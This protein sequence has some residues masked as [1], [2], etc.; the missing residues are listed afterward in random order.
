[1]QSF[2]NNS[3]KNNDKSSYKTK[4]KNKI[5]RRFNLFW[6]IEK[7]EL[8]KFFSITAL[9]FSIL[10]IQ[11]LIRATKDSYVI[12]M[13][14]AEALPFLKSGGVLPAA[15]IFTAIYVK[16]VNTMKPE[17]LFYIIISSF[18]FLFAVYGFIL[19]PN[20]QYLQMSEENALHLA[21]FY[22]K[23][24]WIILIFSKWIF[25][26]FY[27]LAELWPNAAFA[28]LFWQFV[29][30]ITA[31]EE[32]KRFYPLFALLGQTGLIF[33]GV[34]LM[35]NENIGIFLFNNLGL[36]SDASNASRGFIF[37]VICSS[38]IVA[39]FTFRYINIHV[40]GKKSTDV[41]EFKVKASQISIAES[42]KMALRSRYIRLIIIMLICYGFAINICESPWKGQAKLI[43]TSTENYNSFVGGYLLLTGI[44]TLTFVILG[45]GLV[46]TL[47]WFY[48][49]IITPILLFIT[50]SLFFFFSNHS[51]QTVLYFAG[52]FM[53]DPVMIAVV[54]GAIMNV[55]TKSSKYTLFDSTK[56]MTYV[57]LDDEL[58]TRG[59][60]AADVIGIKLGKSISGLFLSLT[61]IIFHDQNF[62]T[63]SKYFLFI[64]VAVCLIWFWSV[65][66]LAKEYKKITEKKH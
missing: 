11:N 49:A 45:S 41:I 17:T 16:L 66:E 55:V 3:P 39:L 56:E 18:I 48:A 62:Q 20:H 29:N 15:F 51:S 50:G 28:L 47:G 5:K 37:G 22:P 46:R 23:L 40:L 2:S 30:S 57:P 34:I 24:K 52:F 4:I 13:I 32:S 43:Y 59:K 27:I 35:Y 19:F 61:L 1:M 65:R 42:F 63:L 53:T 60:A 10:F 64:F 14:A 44:L 26:S 25:S 8:K 7:H 21:T 9:M 38:G 36:F 6:P 31:V 33:S 54:T 12:T 58:K